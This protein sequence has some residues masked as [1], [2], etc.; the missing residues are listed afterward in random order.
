MARVH[1]LRKRKRALSSFQ[2]RRRAWMACKSQKWVWTAF[3]LAERP[4][5]AAFEKLRWACTPFQAFQSWKGACTL[6]R[7]ARGRDTVACVHAF[8]E[9][10][11]RVRALPGRGAARARC[12]RSAEV[13]LHALP[14]P[15]RA[16]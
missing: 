5:R 16:V 10:E 4:A 7:M 13:A 6:F 15:Q 9:R 2:T 1:A 14:H 12:P 11:Q 3:H 8:P